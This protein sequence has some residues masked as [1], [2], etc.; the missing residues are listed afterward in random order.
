MSLVG[1]GRSQTAADK[2]ARSGD[3][4]LHLAIS[5]LSSLGLDSF[6]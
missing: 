5:I 2:A 3:Q 6:L 4:G 1:Q